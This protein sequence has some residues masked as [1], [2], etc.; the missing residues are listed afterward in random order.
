MDV[1]L[2]LDRAAAVVDV[3][4]KFDVVVVDGVDM[5]NLISEDMIRMLLISSGMTKH[6]T[7]I[8]EVIGLSV[9][10]T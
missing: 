4:D 6:V 10:E 3:V 8:V 2:G 7:Q 5:D 9:T 1:T